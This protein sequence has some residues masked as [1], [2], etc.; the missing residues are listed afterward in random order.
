[1]L[2]TRLI[3]TLL[4]KDSGLVKGVAFDSSRRV[5][6]LLPSIKIYNSREVDELFVVDVTASVDGHELDY[7]LIKEISRYCHVPLTVGGG[8]SQLSQVDKVLLAGADKVCINTALF[9]NSNLLAEIAIKYGSQ[10]IVASVDVRLDLNKK[11]YVVYSHSGTVQ[12]DIKFEDHLELLQN[13]GAGEVLLTSIDKDG[14]MLGFD[15]DL[16]NTAKR[17]LKIPFIISGGGGPINNAAAAIMGGASGIAMASAF[18][19]TELTPLEVK[20][21]LN[22]MGISMRLFE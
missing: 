8:L 4:I 10:C 19:F 3:P 12:Q 5:G 14:T 21:N 13:L 11:H 20:K 18:H 16:V 15:I 9:R 17:V 1:M 7:S 22:L 2:K 6:S